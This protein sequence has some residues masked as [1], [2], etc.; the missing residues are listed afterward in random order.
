M[1]EN[2]GMGGEKM[3]GSLE[4]GSVELLCYLASKYRSIMT[5]LWEL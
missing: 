3:A 1:K 2:K 4:E 5:A